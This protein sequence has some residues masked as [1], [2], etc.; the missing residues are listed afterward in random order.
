M[1]EVGAGL[2]K[3]TRLKRGFDGLQRGFSGP[4]APRRKTS[5]ICKTLESRQ[6]LQLRQSEKMRKEAVEC[7]VQASFVMGW[8]RRRLALCLFSKTTPKLEASH[9]RRE[10]ADDGMHDER[11][12]LCWILIGVINYRFTEELRS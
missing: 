9:E 12:L 5:W 1:S 10:D 6:R 3:I 11:V 2:P 7:E 4:A 8:E